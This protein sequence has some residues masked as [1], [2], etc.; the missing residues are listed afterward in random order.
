M[1]THDAT[2]GPTL[3]GQTRVWLRL[4]GLAGFIAGAV[5]YTRLGGELIWFIPVLLAVD[6]SM[7]GYLRGPVA[8]AWGY[9]LFHNWATALVVL[10]AGLVASL[11]LVAMI[12]AVLVAHVGMDRAAGYGLKLTTSFQDTHLGR[13]GKRGT[14][15][16]DAPL[17]SVR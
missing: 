12:G 17:S 7:V 11:P 14:A 6:I 4:E 2:S 3:D 9:N 1:H 8:G 15:G 13:I 16:A 5:I 10:G